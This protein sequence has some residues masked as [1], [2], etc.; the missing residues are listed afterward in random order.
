MEI[1]KNT[2]GKVCSWNWLIKFLFL[3]SW[4]VEAMVV[5]ND[6]IVS[7]LGDSR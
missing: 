6:S 4:K 1:S 3:L 2:D 5:F 7:A